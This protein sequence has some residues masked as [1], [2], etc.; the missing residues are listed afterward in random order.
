MYIYILG[1]YNITYKVIWTV[2]IEKNMSQILW[3]LIYCPHCD[4][5]HIRLQVT[6]LG[7]GQSAQSLEHSSGVLYTIGGDGDLGC[8]TQSKLICST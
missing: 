4:S 5:R 7:T 1:V 2:L 8:R 3:V 6:F